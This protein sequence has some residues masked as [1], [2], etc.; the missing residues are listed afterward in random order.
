MHLEVVKPAQLFTKPHG[1]IVAL[2]HFSFSARSSLITVPGATIGVTSRSSF[3]PSSSA[4]PTTPR[5]MYLEL[6]SAEHG[7]DLGTQPA[8]SWE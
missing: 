1:M 4:S 5:G 6:E 3:N 8:Y 7:L 2:S